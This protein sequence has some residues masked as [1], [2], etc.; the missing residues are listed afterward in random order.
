LRWLERHLQECEQTLSDVASNV[1]LR[2][3]RMSRPGG[4]D[5]AGSPLTSGGFSC[6]ECLASREH[7]K[8]DR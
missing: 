4:V 1:R 5:A 2:R 6:V 3:S 8:R 7:V